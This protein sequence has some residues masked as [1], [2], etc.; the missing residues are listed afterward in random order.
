MLGTEYDVRRFEAYLRRERL[1]WKGVTVLVLRLF[2]AAEFAFGA[3][4]L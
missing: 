1:H 2:L 4:V 3:G